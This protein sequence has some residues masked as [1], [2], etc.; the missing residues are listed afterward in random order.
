MGISDFLLATVLSS[1]GSWGVPQNWAEATEVMKML[2]KN[3]IRLNIMVLFIVRKD[4][5]P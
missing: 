1:I 3:K 4:N 5:K 2:T